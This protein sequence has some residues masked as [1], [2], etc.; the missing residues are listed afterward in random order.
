MHLDG[1]AA[2]PLQVHVVQDLGAEIARGDGP[3]HEQELVGQG[4]LA[5]VN[6]GNYGE[7]ANVAL[8]RHVP[9]I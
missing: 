8:L 3:G 6:M 2:F 4:A 9:T 1:D 7:V 5:V